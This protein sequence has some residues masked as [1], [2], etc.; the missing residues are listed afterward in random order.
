[1]T[2]VDKVLRTIALGENSLAA[3]KGG[4][5]GPQ[6]LAKELVALAN[7][8]GGVVILGVEDNGRISGISGNV[9]RMVLNVCQEKVRPPIVPL[10]REIPLPNRNTKVA[11]VSV[12]RGLAVHALWRKDT[13]QYLIRFGS[14][15]SEASQL[16]L[17]GLFRQKRLVNAEYQPVSGSTLADLDKRR[18]RNYFSD[19]RKQDVPVD[20]DEQSWQTFLTHTL[21]MVDDAAT[22]GAMLLFGKRPNHFL[23]QAGIDAISILGTGKDQDVQEHVHLTGP[24]VP[25][26][27]E[28]NEIVERGLVDEALHFVQR[29]TKDSVE[30]IAGR[31]VKRPVYPSEALREVFVN[32]LMH[33]DYLVTN[34]R[35]ELALHQDY[36]ETRSP[37][38]TTKGLTT[39]QIL[40]GASA[41]RNELVKNVMCDY[42]YAE[43]R[44]LGFPNKIVR[45][46]H[47]H[48]GTEPTIVLNGERFTATL[49]AK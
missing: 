1:M 49:H 29:R 42:G 35:I 13:T 26:L 5:V 47:E 24:A 3:L 20:S 48:N 46:M 10:Y 9:E 38:L 12:T 32:A 23:P 19:I 28:N 34:A 7:S 41:T 8:H 18:L 33:R 6:E 2:T 22:V 39:E 37:G 40:F 11:V 15:S 27:N 17:E 44:G 25:L 21:L 16:E 4:N 43:R 30:A 45:G 14:Q 36:L 31:G